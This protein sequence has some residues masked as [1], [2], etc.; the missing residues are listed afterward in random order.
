MC[1]FYKGRYLISLYNTEDEL[2]NVYDNANE[3]YDEF[4]LL[5]TKDSVFKVLHNSERDGYG[6][7]I[8]FKIHLIDVFDIQADIFMEEDIEF[9]RSVMEDGAKEETNAEKRKKLKKSY[10][11]NRV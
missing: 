6:C 8:G 2:I 5:V 9:L 7:F 1:K 10:E 4:K 11:F 3:M